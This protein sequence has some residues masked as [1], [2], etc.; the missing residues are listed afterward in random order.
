MPLI[1]IYESTSALKFELLLPLL[2][3]RQIK[4]LLLTN[5]VAINLQQLWEFYSY[6]NPLNPH[7]FFFFFFEQKYRIN[8][9]YSNSIYKKKTY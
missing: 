3:M 8:I 7:I 5:L 1:E 6:V 4:I 9:D 2:L